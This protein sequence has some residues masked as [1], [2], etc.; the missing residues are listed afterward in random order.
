MGEWLRPHRSELAVAADIAAAMREQ[1]H[2][3]V[4]FVIVA[5]GPNGASPHHMA[6]ERVIEPG[7]PVVVD[8]GGTMSDGYCSDCTR[9]YVVGGEPPADFVAYYDVLDRSQRAAVA[10]VGPG[11]AAELVDAAARDLLVEA[12]YGPYFLHRTGHGIGLDGHEEP[13]IVAGSRVALEPG[14]AFSIEPGVYL[15][16]RH[17]AR[18]EDIV[19]C[20]SDGVERLNTLGTELVVL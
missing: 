7:D 17:G 8:I 19:V 1:G 10:A 2:A 11:V 3:T 14:M 16:G 4:D 20:T 12:G 6:A 5:S 9:T 13:Y 18:I 15:S